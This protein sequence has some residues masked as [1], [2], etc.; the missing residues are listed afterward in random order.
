MPQP[1]RI[2]P[3]RAVEETAEALPPTR[4]SGAHPRRSVTLRLSMTRVAAR[5]AILPSCQAP[6]PIPTRRPVPTFLA[7]RLLQVVPDAVP[8][9]GCPTGPLPLVAPGRP[10]AERSRT[11][12]GGEL[13]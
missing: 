8:M 6:F 11:G 3:T 10:T 9:T 12:G 5:S 1:A 4:P 13:T 7:R 2:C